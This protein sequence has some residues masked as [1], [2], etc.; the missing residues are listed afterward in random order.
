MANASDEQTWWSYLL[1]GSA[2]PA[3]EI[4]DL[5]WDSIVASAL[6]LDSPQPT[7]DLLPADQSTL[8]VDEAG[9]ELEI[10]H[11]NPSYHGDDIAVDDFGVGADPGEDG[12]H[13]GSHQGHFD[14]PADDSSADEIW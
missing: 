2:D 13:T 1:S 6:D 8:L 14:E 7:D 10:Y 4:P 3:L 5:L 11:D 9:P 12:Y